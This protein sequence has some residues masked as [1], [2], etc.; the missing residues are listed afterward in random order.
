MYTHQKNKTKA[1]VVLLYSYIKDAPQTKIIDYFSYSLYI[2]HYT[3]TVFM[4]TN[5][6]S[7]HELLNIL[8]FT[9]VFYL[10]KKTRKNKQHV[11]I[12]QVYAT[13]LKL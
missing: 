7:E 3:V 6:L 4:S 10:Y 12:T 13:K 1:T 9:Q 5:K 2:T 11:H 8:L